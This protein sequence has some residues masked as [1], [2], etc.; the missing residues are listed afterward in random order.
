MGERIRCSRNNFCIVN[1]IS[2]I[3]TINVIAVSKSLQY[4][5][6]CTDTDNNVAPRN[7]SDSVS[8]KSIF[9][10]RWLQLSTKSDSLFLSC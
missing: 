1:K 7:V 9:T 5:Y 6:V 2:I 8:T 3:I 4:L 10:A